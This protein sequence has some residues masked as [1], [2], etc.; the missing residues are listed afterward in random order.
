LNPRL[1]PFDPKNGF[2]PVGPVTLF[3]GVQGKV[4]QSSS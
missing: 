3:P 2:N 1:D 4:F